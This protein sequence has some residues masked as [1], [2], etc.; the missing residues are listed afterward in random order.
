M[1]VSSS[2]RQFSLPQVASQQHHLKQQQPLPPLILNFMPVLCCPHRRLA[3][4]QACRSA[5]QDSP[6][7]RDYRLSLS[8]L[9]HPH[10]SCHPTLRTRP[11]PVSRYLLSRHQVNPPCFLPLQS[12]LLSFRVRQFTVRERSLSL[13]VPVLW[14]H[15]QLRASLTHRPAK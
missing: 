7:P 1:P 15:C 5:H 3:P 14:P 10:R 9:R 12:P 8:M 4:A 13:Q 2:L 6:L 11:R